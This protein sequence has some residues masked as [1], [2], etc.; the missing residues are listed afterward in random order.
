MIQ[1][2]ILITRTRV[3]AFAAFIF[4]AWGA[5]KLFIKSWFS[6]LRRVPGP[7]SRSFI[8]GNIMEPNKAEDIGKVWEGWFAEFGHVFV[9]KGFFNVRST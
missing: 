1:V 8:W 2:F 7:K 6:P 4:V 3:L 9:A 5:W